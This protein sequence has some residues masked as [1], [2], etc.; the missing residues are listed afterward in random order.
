M[1]AV[2]SRREFLAVTTTALGGLLASLSLP[3]VAQGASAGA[4]LGVFVRIE[5]DGRIA[6]GARGCEIGQGVRT[7]LPMLIAEELDVAWSQVTVEQLPYGLVPSD[8]PPGIAAKYGPQGAGGSTSI[9]EAWIPLRQAGAGVRWMLVQAAAQEWS[10]DAAA[11]RT[12]EGRVVHPDGRALSYGSLAA[13]AAALT[14]PKEDLPLKDPKQFR[15][16]GQP[17]RV[18]DARAIVTGAAAYGLDARLP[19]ALVAVI[20]RCPWFDGDIASLDDAA[21][22]RIPGVRNVV[23]IAGPKAG[24]AIDRNLAAGVAVV[25]DDLWTALKARDALVVKWTRGPWANDSTPALKARAKA[26]L[27]AGDRAEGLAVARTDGD[28]AVAR[29]GAA[30]VSR[31]AIRSRCSRTRHSSPRTR[32]STCVRTARFSSLHCRARA[33]R[34]G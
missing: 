15:I 18:A 12:A 33:V 17:A 31:H 32:S 11:L 28:I 19:N 3:R 4:Q 5:P 25:A 8:Q 16:I 20:A 22:R 27:D 1:S 24:A 9:P 2:L 13:R 23:R 6:I 30:K 7:S 29:A 10:A 26:A 21:A 14:P 34:R